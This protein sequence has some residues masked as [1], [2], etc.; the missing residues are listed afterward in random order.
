MSATPSSPTAISI[1]A[2]ILFL[3]FFMLLFKPIVEIDGQSRQGTWST[4]TFAIEPGQHSVTVFW[5]YLG[6]L[7][8]NKATM[9]V[10]VVE[11]TTT[12]VL[13]RPRWFIF[14]PGKL[15][16]SQAVPAAV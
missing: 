6:L 8:I 2:K 7:P 4:E 9:V 3:N 5:K 15:T 13:Y 12:E 16:V 14:L 1:T 11:G 10:N